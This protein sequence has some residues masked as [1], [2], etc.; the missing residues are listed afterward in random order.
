MT[1]SLALAKRKKY[2]L[3]QEINRWQRNGL[4]IADPQK[5]KRMN[6]VYNGLSYVEKDILNN[7]NLSLHGLGLTRILAPNGGGTGETKQQRADR[8]RA[9]KAAKR[10]QQR[11]E[12]E[13]KRAQKAQ[14]AYERKIAAAEKKQA[15]LDKSYER[16][17]AA[18][19]K[20]YAHD[21]SIET[22]RNPVQQTTPYG[23]DQYGN[24]L[25]PYNMGYGL[26]PQP[27]YDVYQQ[28]Q[29]PYGYQDYGSP[30]GDAVPQITNVYQE[31]PWSAAYDDGSGDYDEYS[32]PGGQLPQMSV[33]D[34]IYADIDSGG[35]YDAL[36]GGFGE[37][38]PPSK[39]PTPIR[40]PRQNFQSKV[41]QGGATMVMVGLAALFIL[42][43]VPHKKG[44]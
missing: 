29:M 26:A 14:I 22:L 15:A 33:P 18:I 30:Y 8:L 9:E 12:K 19:D 44:R 23:Y 27:S 38:S 41:E 11:A 7:S 20:K 28:P 37:L 13:A 3:A 36:S 43:S 10:E 21:L 6:A 16:K 31:S 42:Y 25:Q 24:P 32:L 1:V 34:S 2:D 35:A 17:Q 39:M 40:A 4:D 5:F